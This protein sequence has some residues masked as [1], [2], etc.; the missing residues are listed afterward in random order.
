MNASSLARLYCSLP[1][2]KPIGEFT[3]KIGS[4]QLT[5][6][7]GELLVSWSVSVCCWENKRTGGKS[8]LGF[9]ISGFHAK[10]HHTHHHHHHHL[11]STSNF[12]IQH[13]PSFPGVVLRK[14]F[15]KTTINLLPSMPN[16]FFSFPKSR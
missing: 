11:T 5:F 10:Y 8:H 13:Q 3:L 9:V 7:G 14:W 15:T 1:S 12:S 16:W 2:Q 6:L 4:L